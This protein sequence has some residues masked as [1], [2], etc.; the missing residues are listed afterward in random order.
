MP[1][2]VRRIG[3]ALGVAAGL[4]IALNAAGALLTMDMNRRGMLVDAEN[5]VEQ[6]GIAELAH[7]AAFGG[8]VA[9][10]SRAEAERFAR[11]NGVARVEGDWSGAWEKLY[12]KP[13]GPTRCGY[14]VEVTDTFVAYAV[15]DLDR[16]GEMAEYRQA[17]GQPG[18]WL[19]G[20]KVY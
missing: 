9:A 16:D 18:E 6:I 7:D 14:W 15:C 5:D 13:D 8:F 17:Q 12:W 1:S 4:V 10:G 2:V 19:T 11:A 20:T 3:V